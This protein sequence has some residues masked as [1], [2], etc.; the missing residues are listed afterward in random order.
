MSTSGIT[1]AV[2]IQ[3]VSSARSLRFLVEVVIARSSVV[4]PRGTPIASQQ[5]LATDRLCPCLQVLISV[6]VLKE[7]EVILLGP[8]Y[9]CTIR[10]PPPTGIHGEMLGNKRPR[11]SVLSGADPAKVAVMSERGEA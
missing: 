2:H 7:T 1:G 6:S 8:S 10:D 3:G 4:A 11:P 9:I 5:F